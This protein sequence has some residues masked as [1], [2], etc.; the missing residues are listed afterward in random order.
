[1]VNPSEIQASYAPRIA[2]ALASAAAIREGAFVAVPFEVCGLKLRP[3]SLRD[4][5]HLVIAGNA[6]VAAAAPPPEDPVEALRYWSAHHAQLLWAVWEGS[7]LGVPRARDAFIRDRVAP[8]DYL[9]LSAG[10]AEYLAETFFDA[11]RAA[12]PAPGAPAPEPV[13]DPLRVSFV[14]HD[15]HRFAA[16]YGWPMEQTL[17]LPLKVAF[18]L[19]RLIRADQ[20]LAAGVS[21]TPHFDESDR[22]WGEMLDQLNAPPAAA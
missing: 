10:L 13:N 17:A 14:A 5:L 3:M 21:L 8:L 2:A 1:M 9:A 7:I 15:V 12:R 4:Y 22:L 18:Q 16:A 11:P 19:R 6:H 20:Q